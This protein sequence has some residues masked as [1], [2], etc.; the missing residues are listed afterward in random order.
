M[1]RI[2]G[3][4]AA[5]ATDAMTAALHGFNMEL[6]EGSAKRINDV[7]SKLAAVTASDTQEISTAMTKTAALAHNAGMDVETTSAY[8]AKAIEAT[9]EAPKH[10]ARGHH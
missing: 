7:Y 10:R 6:N 8:L 4:N 1:A 2:A 3:M 9:R 5:D